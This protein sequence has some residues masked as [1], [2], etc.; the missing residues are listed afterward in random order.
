MNRKNS[1]HDTVL[2]IKSITGNCS[3]ENDYGSG[4]FTDQR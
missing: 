1:K 3:S 4:G 2:D